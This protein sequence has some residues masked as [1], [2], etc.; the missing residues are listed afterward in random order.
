MGEGL[1]CS[2]DWETSGDIYV[3]VR[4]LFRFF[5]ILGDADALE[6]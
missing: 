4:S 6:V 3:M 1:L 5:R 2:G